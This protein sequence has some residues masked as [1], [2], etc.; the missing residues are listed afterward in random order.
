MQRSKKTGATSLVNV[1]AAAQAAEE[2][3]RNT[4]H[5]KHARTM[6]RSMRPSGGHERARYQRVTVCQK[7]GLSRQTMRA[8]DASR[9]ADLH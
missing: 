1:G 3:D 8:V 7:A 4:S 9:D 6:G 2:P 5:C